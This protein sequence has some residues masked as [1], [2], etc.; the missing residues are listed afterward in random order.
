MLAQPSVADE[1]ANTKISIPKNAINWFLFINDFND[2][3]VCKK[4]KLRISQWILLLDMNSFTFLQ[5]C[6]NFVYVPR[7]QLLFA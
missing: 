5:I 7:K 4:G 6:D 3:K 2:W 1:A